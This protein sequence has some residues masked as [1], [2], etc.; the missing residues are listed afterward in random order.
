MLSREEDNSLSFKVKLIDF[1]VAA[2]I[3]PDT[4][5]VKGAT[6]LREWSAPET[7]KSHSSDSKIDTWTLGCVMYL[8]C[9]GS[10][11]F[12]PEDKLTKEL[13]FKDNLMSH[14]GS[15]NFSE[16]VDF[17]SRL[18]VVDPEKR[19]SAQEALSHPWLNAPMYQY[20]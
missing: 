13:N 18:I 11:P 17:V 9:T 16:L 4:L 5:L 15:E 1:N 14:S 10:Q 8:L 2:E 6:G 12:D 19:M 7:R 20:Q 3:D